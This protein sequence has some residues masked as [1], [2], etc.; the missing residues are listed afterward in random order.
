MTAPTELDMDELHGAI[1]SLL[2]AKA[3][4]ALED[5]DKPYLPDAPPPRQMTAAEMSV[6]VAL[7]KNSNITAKRNVGSALDTLGDILQ[8]KKGGKPTQADIQ[9]A[10][11]SMEYQ[12]AH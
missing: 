9:A 8:K 7:L 12:G 5:A 3:K 4:G 2:T 6:A 10:M 11:D 1:C